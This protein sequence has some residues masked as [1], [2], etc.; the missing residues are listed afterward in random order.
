MEM[1]GL[2]KRLLMG[3]AWGRLVQ[4]WL[5]P[6]LV[7]FAQPPPVADGLE[8]GAGGGFGAE[9]L[10]DRFPDWRLT[11]TDYDEDMVELARTR[12]GRFSPRARVERA[13]AASLPY[14]D[15]SFDL[16]VSILVWHH[17]DDWQEGLAEAARVLRPGG[18]L[19]SLDVLHPF[20]S[21]VLSRLR[22]HATYGFDQFRA[23]LATGGFSRWRVDRG[24][25]WCLA[26]AQ[27]A[28]SGEQSATP[29]R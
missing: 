26:L 28:R 9:K 19:L 8:V 20:P 14:V 27:T 24:P 23:G 16:V 6:R 29:P 10:L 12:L 5:V 17:I 22:L 18:L 2:E 13:D 1:E 3:T 25:A 4:R 21:G 11:V 7:R 15:R